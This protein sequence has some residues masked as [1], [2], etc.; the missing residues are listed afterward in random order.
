MEANNE[1]TMLALK[2]A[3]TE[4]QD[5]VGSVIAEVESIEEKYGSIVP[6]A[7]TKSDYDFCKQVRKEVQPIKVKM[8]EARKSLKRPIIDMGKLID[9]NLSPLV[10]RL[11][12]VYKPFVDAYQEV[13]NRAKRLEEERQAKMQEAFDKMNDAAMDAIGQT[14]DIIESIMEDIGSWDF[15]PAVFQDRIDE[16][17]KKH[18]DLMQK[19][20]GMHKAQLA[21]EDLERRQAEIEAKEKSQREEQERQERAAREAEIAEQARKE[22]EERH[23]Q[24]MKEAAERAER[25]KAEAEERAERQAVEAARAERERIEAQQRAEQE[26][27]QRREADRKHKGKIHSDIVAALVAGGVGEDNAKQVVKL[28]AKKMAASMHIQ[29]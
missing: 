9:S 1:K 23:Q 26:E 6:T 3:S 14:S 11:E 21:A 16:A 12:S 18:S 20:Q 7:E 15:D 8:E 25:E 10:G 13:D 4:I 27:A 17:V 22:A 2:E 29:Y 5:F 24:Q 28:A 19:L